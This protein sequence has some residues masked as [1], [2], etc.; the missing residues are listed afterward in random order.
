MRGKGKNGMEREGED[1]E[2]WKYQRGLKRKGKEGKQETQ[3]DR[4]GL[5]EEEKT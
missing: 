5:G 1:G 2:V 3:Q 4:G